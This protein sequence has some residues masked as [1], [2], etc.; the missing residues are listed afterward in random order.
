MVARARMYALIARE[1][2]SQGWNFKTPAKPAAVQPGYG[3]AGRSLRLIDQK[4]AALINTRASPLE[5]LASQGLLHSRD[6]GDDDA[7]FASARLEV[8]LAVRQLSD[9]A[10]GLGGQDINGVGGGGF[11]GKVVSDYRID[12]AN[13]VKKVQHRLTRPQWSLLR[14]VAVDGEWVWYAVFKA[15]RPKGQKKWLPPKHELKAAEKIV[16]DLHRALDEAAVVLGRLTRDQVKRRWSR[17][18]KKPR[19][20]EGRNR[21]P[22][23]NAS[24]P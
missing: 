2:G 24:T 9:D 4:N 12:C 5:Y 7:R 1:F 6:D 22:A 15:R 23:S 17:R 8:G 20:S 10:A 18:G 16:I 19:S 21:S 14:A 11:T 3:G 13:L